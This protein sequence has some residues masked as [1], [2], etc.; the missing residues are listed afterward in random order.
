MWFTYAV[1]SDEMRGVH[2]YVPG[3]DRLLATARFDSL[4]QETKLTRP[5]K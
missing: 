1:A 5:L 2:V 4:R 3:P